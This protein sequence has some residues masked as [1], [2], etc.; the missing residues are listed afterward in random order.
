MNVLLSIRDDAWAKLDRF[1]GR[2][3]PLFANY[4][5]VEHL[6]RAAARQAIEQPVAEWNRRLPPG[7]PAYRLEADLV[8]AV[9][10][11]AATGGLVARAVH[12]FPEAET[13]RLEAIEAP[14]LQLVMERLWRAAVAAGTH[15]LT[16]ATLEELGG[17]QQIVENHL[18]D[19]LDGLTGREQ[20][21]AADTLPLPRHA[22]ED[23]DRAFRSRPRR[24]DTATR[25]R[26]HRGAREA[27]PRRERTHLAPGRRP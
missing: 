17:A 8:E 10:D 12:P 1:E 4:I 13:T 14:F 19:A 24:L 21:V 18:L 27:L 7:E 23:E 2:I 16:R 6:S 11:A 9:I 22:V 3:P 26:G 5:R 15:E 20:A 25:A